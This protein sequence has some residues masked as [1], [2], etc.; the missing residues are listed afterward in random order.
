MGIPPQTE[1][2]KLYE[3][4]LLPLRDVFGGLTMKS[5]HLSL[6]HY[7]P[8]PNGCSVSTA[9]PKRSR[10]VAGEFPVKHQ[11]VEGPQQQKNFRPSCNPVVC[12]S[13][14]LLPQQQRAMVKLHHQQEA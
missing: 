11:M 1:V 4:L 2:C 5:S 8:G 7:Q 6:I 10:Q 9:A 14:V 13:A 12:S 3:Q